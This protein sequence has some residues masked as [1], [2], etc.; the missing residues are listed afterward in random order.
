MHATARGAACLEFGRFRLLTRQRELRLGDAT[1]ALGSRAFDVLLILVAAGGELVTKEELL[2]RVWPGAV[3]EESNIQVQVSALRKA[4]GEERNLI[5]TVPLRGY[6]FTGEV[7]ALDAEGR[8][9][10]A[11]PPEPAQAPRQNP[12]NLPAPVSDFIGRET[13][14]RE[15][16]ELLR[17]NRLVSLVGTGGIGKTRLGL[18]AARATLEDFPDG[19]WLAE[20]APLTDPDLVA[21]AINT[22]LGLQSGAGRWTSER[23][24]AALRGRRLLLVLDN[25]EHVIGAAA[26]EAETLLHAVPGAYILATSQEPLGLD[27]ECTYRLSPLEFPAE[28]TAELA[29]ALRHDAV[30]LFVARARAADPH[31]NLSERNAA[32]VATICRRLDGI[33]LAIELAAARAAA[34]GI[35]G[36]A[37]RL[38]LRFHVLTGGRRTALPRHQTLRATLDWSHR[39]LAEPDRIVLRRLAVFAGTFSLEAAASVVADPALA[40]WEV[41]GRIAE[42][43]DKSLVVAD[44]AGAVRRY[45]LLESTDRKSVV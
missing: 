45:R 39:L 43:V 35:E 25:C 4:L 7:R 15:L 18:E 21:S 20:L 13:E 36:L 24:A 32:T 30:R 37:R 42:L 11:A 12:T 44:A 31:F 40:E 16:R 26:R 27:G 22:A 41:I 19:V 38:D 33:P 6:R 8:V 23:L 1:V 29:A 28:E 5:L 9:L 14:L 3:V 10:S 17:H 34:L 2:A